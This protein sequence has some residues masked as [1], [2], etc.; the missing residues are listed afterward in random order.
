MADLTS[1]DFYRDYSSSLDGQRGRL[2]D[3]VRM[4]AW[5]AAILDNRHLFLGKVVLDV[6]CGLGFLSLLAAKAGA[7]KVIG[8]ELP[9]LA[10]LSAKVARSNT[11]RIEVVQGSV[12]EVEL[13]V[14]RVD[15]IVSD[16]M[17]P[18]LV[19]RSLLAEVLEA[20]DR[21]LAP[22]GVMFPERTSLYLAATSPRD[23]EWC[24]SCHRCVPSGRAW[25]QQG[26][27]GFDMESIGRAIGGEARVERVRR[28]ELV[29][30][31]CLLADLRLTSCALED[32][33]TST[34]WALT[35]LQSEYIGSLVLYW[36]AHFPSQEEGSTS[37]STRPGVQ[38]AQQVVLELLEPL[39][40]CRGELVLG[41]LGLEPDWKE[42]RS[43]LGIRLQACFSGA[44]GEVVEENNFRVV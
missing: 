3:R 23:A 24:N 8:L 5:Q 19:H 27:W 38:G 32:L 37:L 44:R 16:W 22:G 25:W 33:A 14:R 18:G 13:S 2:G 31:S 17:G 34:P 12:G 41:R 6:G 39:A 10:E 35:A 28:E 4:E 43:R 7:A 36:E 26:V 30:G 1:E 9:G 42:H 40:V 29:T 11:S 20:R 15:V 21:W